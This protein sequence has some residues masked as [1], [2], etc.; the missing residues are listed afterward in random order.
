MK[1]ERQERSPLSVMLNHVHHQY[2]NGLTSRLQARL[3]FLSPRVSSH[4]TSLVT[5]VKTNTILPSTM[6]NALSTLIGEKLERGATFCETL[7][8]PNGSLY[9]IPFNARRAAKFDPV[10]KSITH[11]GP[12]FGGGGK[13]WSKGAMTDCGIIYCSPFYCS[14]YAG[15]HGIV[16]IDTNTDDVTELDVN[17]LPE[18]GIGM[19]VSCAVALDGCIYFMPSC[20]RRILKIDPNNND[21]MKSV[22]EEMGR[23]RHKYSGTFVGIDGYVYGIP[24]D[25]ECILKY[26]PINDRDILIFE[27][28]TNPNGTIIFPQGP[29][30]GKGCSGGAFGRDGCIYALA[31]NSRVLK[32]D[33][34]NQSSDIC[35]KEVNIQSG[36][37]GTGWGDAVLGIDGCIYWPPNGASRTLKYDT[38]SNQTALVG[39]KCES[40]QDTWLSGALA[41][42]GVIYCIPSCANEVL[43]I[44][45]LEE[46][47]LAMKGNMG[48]HSE[49]LGFLFG[50]NTE[51]NNTGADSDSDSDSN[52]D[53]DSDSNSDSDSVSDSVSDSDSDSDTP[54]N[55]TNFDCAIT[56][57][58]M[59]KIL[60]IV[61]EH[62]PP[63]N[64]VC[65]AYGCGLY[66]F[67]LAASYKESPLSVVYVLLRQVPF[68]INRN[69]DNSSAI[70]NVQCSL[71]RK[72]SAIL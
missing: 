44:N 45:P 5:I 67:M 24:N 33:T 23:E 66:P 34:T 36:C 1:S 51:D 19:W 18:R 31:K 48:E 8:A 26:D 64:K 30:Q 71:K 37:D 15:D 38:H 41:T 28:N 22:G 58:G 21:A 25:S 52:S 7:A 49:E 61:Q 54:S 55:R 12:D 2:M 46:F 39:N 53:S 9:G 59:E 63:A 35:Y 6:V 56:K 40:E 27:I 29:D 47:A 69:S 17:L 11:I 60:E 62:I 16:K 3:S 20:A 50:I 65:A 14:P 68:L 72:S 32:I 4:K 42:D 13:K 70:P 43:T 57:F 10:H